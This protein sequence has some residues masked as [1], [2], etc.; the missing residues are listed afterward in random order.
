MSSSPRIEKERLIASELDLHDL[1]TG[2]NLK[3]VNLSTITYV[4]LCHNFLK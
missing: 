4:D 3:N 2:L 1:K